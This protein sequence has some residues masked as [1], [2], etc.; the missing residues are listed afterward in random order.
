[1]QNV[2]MQNAVSAANQAGDLLC[3]PAGQRTRR[4]K[5]EGQKG[6]YCVEQEKWKPYPPAA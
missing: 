3:L 1:M 6:G 4:K 2:E 5:R